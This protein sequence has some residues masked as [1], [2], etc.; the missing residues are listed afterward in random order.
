MEEG[1][2]FKASDIYRKTISKNNR[3]PNQMNSAEVLPG[4]TNFSLAHETVRRS[5]YTQSN[6]SILT[7]Q[8]INSIKKM[9]QRSSSDLHISNTGYPQNRIKPSIDF[10]SHLEDNLSSSYYQ[11]IEMARNDQSSGRLSN[12]L[13]RFNAQNPNNSSDRQIHQA[14]NQPSSH[15]VIAKLKNHL[16]SAAS[17]EQKPGQLS[18]LTRRSVQAQNLTQNQT[19]ASSYLQEGASTSRDH[20]H[21]PKIS[22]AFSSKSKNHLSQKRSL[23]RGPES[24]PVRQDSNCMINKL[25]DK[26]R[27]KSE[28]SV[29]GREAGSSSP[30]RIVPGRNAFLR[31]GYLAETTLGNSGRIDVDSYY[32]GQSDIPSSYFNN[33][34]MSHSS[35]QKPFA[36]N[37]SANFKKNKKIFP[38]SECFSGQPSERP[39]QKINEIELLKNKLIS[40]LKKS[41][42]KK[43]ISISS[44]KN[45]FRSSQKKLFHEQETSKTNGNFN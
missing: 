9:V 28:Y 32:A 42:S 8:T 11:K 6:K 7:P 21:R 5:T 19:Q 20:R 14:A 24:S 22:L 40:S 34:S 13:E 4:L 18:S 15:S 35:P 41:A 33:S 3:K 17:K 36:T 16:Q 2:I 39:K 31:G 29:G 30:S 37:I 44:K 23:S 45:P 25:K 1:F 10:S 27:Q 26:L 43:E 12:Y 38:F